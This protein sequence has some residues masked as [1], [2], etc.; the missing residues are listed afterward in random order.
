MSVVDFHS[1][2]TDTDRVFVGIERDPRQMFPQIVGR[3]E[4]GLSRPT[5]PVV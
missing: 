3:G 2:D 4:S 5:T 1:G